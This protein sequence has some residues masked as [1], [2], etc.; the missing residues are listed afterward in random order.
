MWIGLNDEAQEGNW[1]WITGIAVSNAPWSPSE[2]N[3]SGNY[4]LIYGSGHAVSGLWDDQPASWA[5]GYLLE[6]SPPDITLDADGDGYADEEE[7]QWGTDP[8]N[9]DSY[10][11][12]YLSF[13]SNSGGYVGVSYNDYYYDSYYG[14]SGIYV[15]LRSTVTLTAFADYDYSFSGW[16][17]DVYGSSSTVDLYMDGNKSVQANFQY[18]G[19]GGYWPPYDYDSD[20]DGIYD[21][22]EYSYGTDPYDYDTDNDGIGDGTEVYTYYTNPTMADSDGD[23]LTDG[24]EVNQHYTNPHSSDSDWDGY[25]DGEEVERGSSPTDSWS[26]PQVYLSYSS[27]TGGR[28]DATGVDYWWGWYGSYSGNVALRSTVTLTAVP[29]SGYVFSAWS[30]DNSSSTNPLELQMDANKSVQASFEPDYAD[31]DGDGLSNYAEVVSHY[32]NPNSFDSDGD[33]YSDGEEIERKSNPNDS[34]SKPLGSISGVVTDKSGVGLAG[35]SV[36]A[37]LIDTSVD[38]NGYPSPPPPTHSASWAITDENGSYTMHGLNNGSYQ[39]VFRDYSEEYVSIWYDSTPQMESANY[40]W[41]SKLEDVGGINASL[42]KSSSISGTVTDSNG[43]P[44]EGIEVSILSYD[45]ERHWWSWASYAT[46]NADGNYTVSGISAGAYRI[47]FRDWW[48]GEF[49]PEYYNNALSLETAEDIVLLEE[50]DRVG[51]D[52]SLTTASRITGVVTDQDG[53]PLE[54]ISVSVYQYDAKD[55]WWHWVTSAETDELG[56][57]SLGGLAAGNYRVEFRDYYGEY[58]VEYYENSPDLD[59]AKDIVVAK[60]TDVSGINASMVKASGIS[61]VVTGPNGQTPLANV[62][63][64]LERWT[65]DD[66]SWQDQTVTEQDGSYQ[67]DGLPAGSYR[68]EFED[69]S[70][71]Y[72]LEYYN[73]EVEFDLAENIVLAPEQKVE[74]INAS[75]VLGSR[76]NGKVT[77]PDGTPLSAVC[78]EVFRLQENGQWDWYEDTEA[79]ADG[80]YEIGGLP[81][82]TYR[83][84]FFDDDEVYAVQFYKNNGNTMYFELARNIVISSPQTIPGVNAKF[85]KKAGT[86][87]GKVTGPDASTPLHEVRIEAYR[88]DDQGTWRLVLF[89]DLESDDDGF[90]DPSMLPGG[91]YRLKFQKDGYLTKFYGDVYSISDAK[92]IVLGDGQVVD[93]IHVS[94]STEPV[95]QSIADFANIGSKTFGDVPF[96]VT[97]P[98]ATSNLPV[99]LSV[100]SGPATISGNTVT[101]TGAGTVVLAANQ[102]GNANYNAASEVTTTFS[103]AK[104]TQT[105]GSFASIG[106]KIYGD[107]PFAVTPPTATSN[108]PVTLSVKSGPATIS[109]NTV[110]LTGAGTVVLAANQTGNA[111]YNAASEVTTSFGV[112]K[113]TQTIGSFASIGNKIYGDGPFAVTPPTATSGLPVTLSVKSGPA[114]ISNNTVTLTGAG[115]VE[116]AANQ[117]GNAEHAAATEVTTSFTVAKATQTIAAFADLENK[118][119]GDASFAVAVPSATSGLPVTLS[120]K[121][122]P[123]TI[124]GNTVTING[125]GIVMLAANQSGNANYLAA[126]PV[127]AAFAVMDIKSM[128]GDFVGNYD[129]DGAAELQDAYDY[130]GQLA[131]KVSAGGAFSGSLVI[132]GSRL[133]VKGKFDKEGNADLVIKTKTLSEVTVEL[134]IEPMNDKEYQVA[135]NMVWPDQ[136]STPFNCYPVAYTGKGGEADFPLGGKQINSLM[137]SQSTSGIDFGHG[138]AMIKTSKDG[139]LKFTGRAADGSAITG[140]TRLVKDAFEDILAPVSFPL[141]AVKGLLHGVADIDSNPEEGQYHL[142]SSSEWTWVRLPQTKAKTY[143]EGF[144]EKLGLYGQVWSFTKGQ[145]ALPEAKDGFTFQVDPDS[146]LLEEPLELSGKWPSS[147]KPVWDVAPPKGFTFKVNTATGQISG[148]APRKVNGKAA[149]A[150]S[151]QGLLVRPALDSYDGAPLFGG[152][153]LLGTESSGVVELTAP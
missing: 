103:V 124:S 131:L 4:G 115:T 123:A 97:P 100:K 69:E 134:L 9:S 133:G 22:N 13:S 140:A 83:V 30:G 61:G 50:E 85:D 16:G 96:A 145:S 41:I 108:L 76:I 31:S 90:F 67:F 74:N 77:G 37:Y 119:L 49:A 125:T 23:G 147:N 105:I 59:S 62:E 34:W 118:T 80:T 12:V 82:G 10:P 117:S 26:K 109:G 89:G 141:S 38:N 127:I 81:N 25:S 7:L 56:E 129:F 27:S 57:Y 144:A 122:G 45:E 53:S 33:G 153:C 149:K 94:L 1:N 114:T 42:S 130:N 136:P 93:G 60:S 132:R 52:A 88:K 150:L 36:S 15:P 58:A 44:L 110:T 66:W 92:D 40:V 142:A 75:L 20:G 87:S 5:K 148:A 63:V 19:G 84:G 128:A 120:V 143:K 47:E 104:A 64:E 8:N 137:A 91:A 107:G 55:E 24:D 146:V 72:A 11:Q 138:F 98:T 35:I 68:I 3:G 2:P 86:I 21:D 152:G 111:N 32:T 79:N 6:T 54:Q 14:S 43:L 135:A 139:T 29:D 65:G 73:N 126:D 151:Y 112:A 116:L 106:N 48:R 71:Q 121:S 113:A 17:G 101:L 51:I 46:T 102:A 39:I 18:N 99:T 70:G 95:P 78:V 28:I